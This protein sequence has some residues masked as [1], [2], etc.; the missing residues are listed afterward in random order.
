MRCGVACRAGAQG[1]ERGVVDDAVARRPF[2]TREMIR[3]GWP[4]NSGPFDEMS[5]AESYLLSSSSGRMRRVGG[6]G[7]LRG[8]GSRVCTVGRPDP[9][10]STTGSSLPLNRRLIEC[11]T[12]AVRRFERE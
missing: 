12:R 2:G 3:P 11:W 5:L 7:D 9:A 4:P 8:D 1:R 10:F 6:G